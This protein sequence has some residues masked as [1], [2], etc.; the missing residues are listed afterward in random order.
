MYAKIGASIAD[1]PDRADCLAGALLY[2]GVNKTTGD[3]ATP[4]VEPAADDPVG[5]VATA[6][7]LPIPDELKQ[8]ERELAQ[9]IGPLAGVLVRKASANA[10]S[11]GDLYLRLAEHIDDPADRKGFL[12]LQDAEM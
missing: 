12:S 4:P 7:L 11:L 5:A 1:E 3:D 9:H 2:S 8:V 6:G 10:T